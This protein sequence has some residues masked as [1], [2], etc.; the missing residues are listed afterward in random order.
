[1][2]RVVRAA[3]LA[4]LLAPLLL[5]ACQGSLPLLAPAP[6]ATPTITPTA[7]RTPT[8]TATS[9]PT[10]T[11]SP[12]STVTPLPTPTP[13]RPPAAS[14][15]T[16]IAIPAIRLDAPV[17]LSASRVVTQGG[18]VGLQ[19]T[20]PA[21]GAGFHLGSAFPG[22][23]GN[24]VLSGHHNIGDQVFRYLIDLEVGDEVILYV[25]DLAY[26][27]RVSQKELLPEKGQPAEVR[28]ANARWIEPTEDERVTLVTCWPYS[29]NSHR[30]IIVA[31][32][33]P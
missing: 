7:A 29:G 6:T 20:V 19:Y 5:L 27:Y 21:A 8:A 13:S 10:A 22:H 2:P 28:R 16:R 14:P 26:R 23:G 24:T 9:L 33:V 3:L 18:L 4:C 15:P 12:S 11:A 31:L 25:G 30:L 17:V 1:M 32:P